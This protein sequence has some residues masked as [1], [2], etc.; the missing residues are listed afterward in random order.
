M[1]KIED[2][3]DYSAVIAEMKAKITKGVDEYAANN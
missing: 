1:K 2:G 3:E